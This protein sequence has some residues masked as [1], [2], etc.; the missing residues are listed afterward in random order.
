M[1][2][3]LIKQIQESNELVPLGDPEPITVGGKEG[4]STSLRSPSPF[5]DA[6]GQPQLERDWLVTVAQSDGSMIFMIFVA[7]EPDFNHLKPT[8]EAMVK[9]VQ[10]R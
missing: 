6:Q 10:F 7:P 8:Y 4:R 1:T 3:A 2:A 5:P 9:S